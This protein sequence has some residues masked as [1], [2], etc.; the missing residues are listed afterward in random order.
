M[1]DIAASP[2]MRASGFGAQT[3]WVCG[4]VSRRACCVNLQSEIGDNDDS[5]GE[6]LIYCHPD[7]NTHGR[8]KARFPLSFVF[9]VLQTSKMAAHPCVAGNAEDQ[10]FL[11]G[12]GDQLTR[13]GY[14][15]AARE[16]NSRDPFPRGSS[17]N[18]ANPSLNERRNTVREQMR[19]LMNLTPGSDTS[20]AAASLVSLT[21]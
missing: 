18:T 9:H 12:P 11:S 20:A 1:T 5:P 6:A 17:S 13:F 16:K 4:S 2:C 7:K 14:R 10:R 15:A 8:R 3:E 21:A 19:G